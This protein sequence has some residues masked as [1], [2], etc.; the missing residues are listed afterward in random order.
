MKKVEYKCN[1]CSE[2]RNK[3]DL[4]CMFYNL[5]VIPQNYYISDD[6]TKSDIHICK[7]CIDV[8]YHHLTD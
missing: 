1:L 8:L 4:K 5:A 7:D 6:L 3:E 2:V